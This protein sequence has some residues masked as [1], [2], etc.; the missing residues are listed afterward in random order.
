M[1]KARKPAKRT[2]SDH[3]EVALRVEEV[4]VLKLDGAT[5]REIRE[6]AVEKGWGVSDTQLYRYQASAEKL[7]DAELKERRRNVV[8]RHLARRERLYAK[9]IKCDD[10]RVALEVMRDEAK[11]RGLYPDSEVKELARLVTAQTLEIEELKRRTRD[12]NADAAVTP[13]NQA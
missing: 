11:L 7:L 12:A 8:N 5:I 3:A 9:A 1:G 2:K 4:L 6:H 10:I 13:A